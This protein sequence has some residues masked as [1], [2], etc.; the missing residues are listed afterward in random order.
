MKALK[1]TLIAGVIFVAVIATEY[2]DDQSKAVTI[3]DTM[4]QIG[5]IMESLFPRILNADKFNAVGANNETAAS[6]ERLAQLFK[7]AEPHFSTRSPTYKVS[8][9]VISDQLE[10]A[11]VALK[12]KNLNHA[13][14]I[15]KEFVSICASCHTQDTKARV[16][17]KSMQ[18]SHFKNDLEYAEFNYMTRNYP[19]AVVFYDQYLR[20]STPISE[21][22]LLTALKRLLTIYAQIYNQPGEGEKQLAKYSNHAAHTKFSQKSLEEWRRGLKELDT[23]NVSVINNVTFDIIEKKVQKVL[24]NLEEPGSAEFPTKKEKVARVWLRGLL[25]HYLNTNPPKQEIPAILYWLGIIDRSINYSFYYSLADSYLKECML[26]Y[27]SY[28][29]AKKCYQEYEQY[30][31]FAYSGSRGTDIPQDVQQ[32]LNYL[33]IKVYDAT[34]PSE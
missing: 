20:S 10:E 26:R 13:R 28:P 16:L 19:E 23:E 22:E 21:T 31:M 12:H 7:E 6:V 15:L 25:Y 5:R 11:G 29:Y 17:F 1:W 8:F 3:N 2:T 33:K 32:E 9:D 30:L 27:T 24:G 14:N 18:R 4:S 34:E